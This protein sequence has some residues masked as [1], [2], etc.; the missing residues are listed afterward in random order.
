MSYDVNYLLILHLMLYHTTSIPFSILFSTC[1]SSQT[2]TS[3]SSHM[4]PTVTPT[5]TIT[6]ARSKLSQDP[7]LHTFF[8]VNLLPQST[9]RVSQATH[10]IFILLQLLCG[11]WIHFLI[12][13]MFVSLHFSFITYLSN[14]SFFF[15]LFP[16]HSETP[17]SLGTFSIFTPSHRLTT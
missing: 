17:S 11:F 14:S 3:T 6:K 9:Q 5:P 10:F 1:R 8:A 16:L 2:S 13:T 15:L 7:F 12:N 4:T